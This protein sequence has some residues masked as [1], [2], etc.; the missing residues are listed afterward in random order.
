MRRSLALVCLLFVC[1]LVLVPGCGKRKVTIRG[2]FVKNGQV[3]TFDPQQYVTLQF[4]PADADNARRSYSATID[5]AAGSYEVE[6]L[7][8]EYRISFYAPPLVDSKTTRSNVVS[9]P[10]I[11]KKPTASALDTTIYD[12]R[13]STTHDITVP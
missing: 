9:S 2:K 6:L 11:T 4:V 7:A 10:P 1:S 12:F 8:G 13:S 5:H 3:Q